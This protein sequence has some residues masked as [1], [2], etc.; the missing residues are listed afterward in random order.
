VLCTLLRIRGVGGVGCRGCG[1]GRPAEFFKKVGETARVCVDVRCGGV[2]RLFWR[3]ESFG[4]EMDS[5]FKVAYHVECVR[6]AGSRSGRLV[7][8]W[9]TNS[10]VSRA[11]DG[12]VYLGR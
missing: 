2:A 8:S 4:V 10:T 3:L 11:Y 7:Y 1:R 9:H 5:I 12:D 6:S